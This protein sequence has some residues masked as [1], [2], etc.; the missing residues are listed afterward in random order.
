LEAAKPYRIS[1]EWGYFWVR[2]GEGPYTPENDIAPIKAWLDSGKILVMGIPIYTDFPDYLF[3]GPMQYY[4]LTP[5]SI[6][7]GWH[8]ITIV[9]Y[10]NNINPSGSDA[11][12]RGGFKMV[13]SWGT[14][15]NGAN[16]GYLYLSYDFVK[17]YAREAWSMNDLS[18]DTPVITSLSATSG[19][20]WDT[21]TIY[22]NNFGTLR[23]NA[24]VTFN[25]VAA[26]SLG[27][28]NESII[29]Q[30]PTGAT[31]GP[32]KVY[33]WD[34]DVSNAVDFAVEGIGPGPVQVTS[35]TPDSAAQFGMNIPIIDLSGSGFVVGATVRLETPLTTI[36]ATNVEVASPNT[37]TC[38]FFFF[39]QEPGIF[40]VI[41]TNPDGSEGRLEDAF[42]VNGLCGQG[43][44]ASLLFFGITIGLLGLVETGSLL[45]RRKRKRG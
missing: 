42:T 16:E 13:N 30:V 18:P 19:R 10:D 8:A 17:K 3:S 1:D 43:A 27:F 11:D 33:N 37:I 15:W 22:G 2:G 26:T 44:G 14:D 34:G 36:Y 40:D 21:I 38:D 35:I 5:F 23:R 9:G 32:V 31:T 39:G 6:R 45:R 20:V 7:L 24:K 41:V 4:N 12:L 29:V 28:T 25:G